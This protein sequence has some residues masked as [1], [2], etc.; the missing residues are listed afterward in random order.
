MGADLASAASPQL[1]PRS[2]SR[3]ALRGLA[4]GGGGGPRRRRWSR[5]SREWGVEGE[6]GAYRAGGGSSGKSRRA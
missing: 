5:E 1:R 4:P 3:S 6:G 2:S